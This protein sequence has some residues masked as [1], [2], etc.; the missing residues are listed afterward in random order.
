MDKEIPA[1]AIALL[2]KGL[3]FIP[4]PVENALE[5][6]LDMR[7]NTNRILNCANKKSIQ[8]IK[9]TVPLRLAHKKYTA[10]PPAEETSVNNVVNKIT[11]MHNGRLQFEKPQSIKKNITKDEHKGLQW[12]INETQEEH[13]AVVKADKGGA[14]LIVDPKLLESVVQEKLDNQ[15]VYT[16]LDND[17]TEYISDELFQCWLDGKKQKFV[18]AS[19]AVRV[20]G[21]TEKNNKSTLSHFKPGTSYFYPML[22]I[23]KLSTE[24]LVPG[25]KPPARL[26]TALQEGIS[27]R[28]DVFIADRFF[29]ELE[30]SYC[31]DLLKDTTAALIWLD[32]VDTN[33]PS[34]EKKHF[35]AFTFDFKSLYDNLKPELVKEALLDAMQKC[36]PEWNQSKRDWLI[37]LVDISLRASIGKFKGKFYLQKNGVPTGGSLCVQLANITVFYIMN[38]TVYSQPQ[39]MN[40]VKEA[41]RY[42]DDGAGFY[43]GSARS[44][45]TWMN[46]VN[47]AL[48]LT[49]TFKSAP[50]PLFKYVQ[51]TASNIG[52]KLSV[53]KS[54][55]L[56]KRNGCTLPCGGRSNCMCCKLVQ[57]NESV[58]VVVVV[59][60]VGRRPG[61]TKCPP[62]Q[63]DT[64]LRQL[65]QRGQL[66][67]SRTKNVHPGGHGARACQPMFQIV[68]VVVAPIAFGRYFLIISVAGF[69]KP[70]MVATPQTR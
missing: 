59:L 60:T 21:I 30:Q 68:C 33:Y 7:L 44:F 6:Q 45:K 55:A 63:R 19:E 5:E 32:T 24:E 64:R 40:N 49:D 23:H 42:I 31:E 3:N 70:Q 1:G 66:H 20:M 50:K 62:C 56:G 22:K 16:K 54:L 27:K 39:M 61:A 18:T 4:T 67:L 65:C 46:S 37:S 17:P 36:R 34:T 57:S 41:K 9:P 15:D 11:E 25:V 14:I 48:T 69:I 52:S 51:K 38:K 35:K 47:N 13:I 12:L 28:S 26:V 29:K 53:L 2:G 10:A 58:V 43:V 8:T